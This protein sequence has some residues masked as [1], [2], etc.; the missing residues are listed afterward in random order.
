MHQLSCRDMGMPG[1]S[2][3][4]EGVN[5]EEVVAQYKEHIRSNH[6]EKM[7]EITTS[8]SEEQMDEMMNKIVEV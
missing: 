4:T 6:P 7:T 3:R 8:M 1:C 2:F 5:K